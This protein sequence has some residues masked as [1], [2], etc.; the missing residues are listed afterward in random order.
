[1]PVAE[2]FCKTF[3]NADPLS[4]HLNQWTRLVGRYGQK[5][6]QLV[7]KQLRTMLLAMIPDDL[8][9]E[10]KHPLNAHIRTVEQIVE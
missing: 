2:S 8:E 10:L 9:A 7:P 6:A 5:L 3:P 1:M 4:A